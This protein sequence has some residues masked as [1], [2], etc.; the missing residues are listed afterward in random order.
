MVYKDSDEMV[1]EKSD[2]DEESGDEDEEI[3]EI[4]IGHK[5]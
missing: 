4:H 2:Q 3:K 5:R 1:E